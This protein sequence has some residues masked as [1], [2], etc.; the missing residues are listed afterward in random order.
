MPEIDLSYIQS[1]A[2]DLQRINELGKTTEGQRLIKQ[3]IASEVSRFINTSEIGDVNNITKQW[4]SNFTDIVRPNRF[5]TVITAG[6]NFYDLTEFIKSISLPAIQRN[7]LTFKRAGKT[8][9]IPLN[10]DSPNSISL[11][12]YQDVDNTVLNDLM[13]MINSYNYDFVNYNDVEN[14][15]TYGSD[16]AILY[17]VKMQVDPKDL[18]TDFWNKLGADIL[19]T[20]L[21]F[22]ISKIAG[23]TNLQVLNLALSRDN[24]QNTG[25]KETTAKYFNNPSFLNFTFKVIYKNIFIE[26]LNEQ[27]YDM[28]R[29]NTYQE[30]SATI[31]FQDIIIEIYELDLKSKNSIKGSLLNTV[32]LIDKII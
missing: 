7:M 3:I 31:H 11:T 23:N 4:R 6:E 10:M 27:T 9:K 32:D 18:T 26:N 28:E 2:S 19:Q 20:G 22:G 15:A 5:S 17:P 30:L 16:L 29:L 8:I 1:K 21:E 14:R 13:Y 25:N 24:I 12:L